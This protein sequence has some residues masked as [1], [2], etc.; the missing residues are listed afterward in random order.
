[1]RIHAPFLSILTLLA[2][3]L[4]AQREGGPIRPGPWQ[5]AAKIPP[6]WVVHNSKNYQVQSEAGPEKAKRLALHMEAMNTIYRNLFPPGKSGAKQQTIKIFKDRNG[7]LG[8]GAPQGSA[9]YYASGD[10]EMV[11]YDTGRWS[12]APVEES[13]T[14]GAE[15]AADRLARRMRHLQQS[16]MMDTLG[17]AAHE[18]WHQYFHWYVGSMVSL[19][20]WINEGMGDYF[21]AAAGPKNGTN[22]GKGK[23]PAKKD[24]VTLGH[25]NDARLDVVIAAHRQDR[26][27]P[28]PKFLTMEQSEYYANPSICYA[29]GW[30]LCQFLLHEAGKKYEKVIPTYLKIVRD[31][32]N[33]DTATKKAFKGIDLE[34]MDVEFK[35][36]IATLVDPKESAI[37]ELLEEVNGGAPPVPP[38]AGGEPAPAGG[39]EPPTPP[40]PPTPAGGGTGNGGTG[41]GGGGDGA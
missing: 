35:A 4:P 18:G 31:D 33:A 7:Y 20:S 25:L 37:E 10:R 30:A 11:C 24:A 38:G 2:A 23:A 1:M 40:V 34:A 13:P 28:L 41:N 36:W 6:G 32:T 12:D 27:E 17:C 39:E 22:S 26:L 14:T 19:P 8:Y 29:E 3:L 21:Y 15:T 5:T 16:D 9:A